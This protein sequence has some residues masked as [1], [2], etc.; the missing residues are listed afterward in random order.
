MESFHRIQLL[1]FVELKSQKNWSIIGI[2]EKAWMLSFLV[3]KRTQYR[4]NK[5]RARNLGQGLSRR[6][7]DCSINACLASASLSI[8]HPFADAD[9]VM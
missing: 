6:I 7:V 3:L 5:T 4:P 8:G 2:A 9:S 1:Y